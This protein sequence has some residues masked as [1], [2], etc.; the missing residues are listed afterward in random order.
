MNA[1]YE[2]C[3]DRRRPNSFHERDAL[4]IVKQDDFNAMGLEKLDVATEVSILSHDD[5]LDATLKNCDR[6][7]HA[8]T[9]RRAKLK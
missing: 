5:T 9:E 7:H 3:R 1:C 8:R 4:L 6:T 2:P